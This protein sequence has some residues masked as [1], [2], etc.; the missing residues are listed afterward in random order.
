MILSA[1]GF[2]E[3]GL[4][5]INRKSLAG[6]APATLRLSSAHSTAEL[7]AQRINTNQLLRLEEGGNRTRKYLISSQARSHCGSA[8]GLF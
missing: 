8:P 5:C 7:Q 3:L 1:A 2:V 4:C 6:V